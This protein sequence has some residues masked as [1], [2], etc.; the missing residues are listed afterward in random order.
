MIESLEHCQNKKGLILYAYVIMSNNRPIELSTIEMVDQRLDYIHSESGKGR[1][2][3]R[4]GTL[5]L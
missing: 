1:N 2:C 5:C 3:L 4:T